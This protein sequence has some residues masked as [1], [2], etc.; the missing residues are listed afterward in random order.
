MY[1]NIYRIYI[2]IYHW[3]V[4]IF[5]YIYLNTLPKSVHIR[6]TYELPI[7]TIFTIN[8]FIF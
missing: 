4:F 6:K 7:I 2:E 3:N 1:T 5:Y 8:I